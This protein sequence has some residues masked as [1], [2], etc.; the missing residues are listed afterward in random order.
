MLPECRSGSAHILRVGFPA[1]GRAARVQ[2]HNPCDRPDEHAAR[3]T[4]NPAQL[5][6]IACMAVPQ[7]LSTRNH[8]ARS[9]GQQCRRCTGGF[10]HLFGCMTA[11]SLSARRMTGQ[12]TPAHCRTI[13]VLRH[14]GN[15]T[16]PAG[17]CCEPGP[18]VIPAGTVGADQ[19]SSHDIDTKAAGSD[20]QRTLARHAARA[21]DRQ[22]LPAGDQDIQR[23]GSGRT[24]IDDR[25]ALYVCAD[26]R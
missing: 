21:F 10:S 14:N 6:R 25:S 11:H 26:T 4:G 19:L 16:W 1:G 12:L 17:P 3:L 23:T 13:P 15:S 8:P 24:R 18:C 5:C 20:H 9:P 2:I 22:F 7:R